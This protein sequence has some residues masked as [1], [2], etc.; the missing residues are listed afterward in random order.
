MDQS[1][2][3]MPVKE[4]SREETAPVLTKDGFD[5]LEA[6]GLTKLISES[7][8]SPDH[9]I[10]GSKKFPTM[11]SKFLKKIRKHCCISDL[12]TLTNGYQAQ[13]MCIPTQSE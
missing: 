4:L 2:E 8:D 1:L 9:A 6:A 3:W 11:N 7:P 10:K 13:L 12:Q 5:A